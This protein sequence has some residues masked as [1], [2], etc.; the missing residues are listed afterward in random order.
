MVLNYYQDPGHGW[1]KV[2]RRLLL[3]YRIHDKI[4]NCSYESR[5]GM[6]VFLEEDCDATLFIQALKD[7]GID[8]KLKSFHSNKA[9]KIRSYPGYQLY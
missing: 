3:E 2:P 8:Y 1:I 6:S 7:R 5:D 4:S 9:S